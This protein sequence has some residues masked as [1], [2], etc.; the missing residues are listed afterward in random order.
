MIV[1]TGFRLHF[2][3]SLILFA[4]PSNLARDQQLIFVIHRL[5][6]GFELFVNLFTLEFQGRRDLATLLGEGFGQ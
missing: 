1:F 6:K 2:M 4:V 3:I 5:D